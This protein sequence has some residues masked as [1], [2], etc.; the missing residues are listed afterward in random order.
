MHTPNKTS[1]INYDIARGCY[2]NG[3]YK[4]VPQSSKFAPAFLGTNEH[5]NQ[6]VD[7]FGNNMGNVLTIASSGDQPLFYAMAGAKNI[8]TFDVSFC[9]HALMDLKTSAIQMLDYNEYLNLLRALRNSQV[10]KQDIMMAP[11]MDK[12]LHAMPGDT[13]QFVQQM[14]NCNILSGGIGGRTDF[15]TTQPTAS[16][17][18]E[19]RRR[20]LRPFNFI[21]SDVADLHTHLNTKYDII[22][23]SNV[24][25]WM[26]PESVAPVLKTLFPYLKPNGYI[27]GTIFWSDGFVENGFDTAARHFGDTA[28][29]NYAATVREYLI[30]LQRTK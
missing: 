23:V 1:V 28:R 9:A 24:F 12:I 13:A 8:D 21:W 10:S 5:L 25:E 26:R 14:S 16:E 17:Y 19:M 2:P 7:F 15:I 4:H 30:A 29:V 3:K 27:L 18:S 22:N 20:V 6:S 11:H